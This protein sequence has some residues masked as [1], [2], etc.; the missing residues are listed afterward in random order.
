MKIYPAVDIKD[1]NCVRLYQGEFST[2]HKVA[3]SPIDSALD[4]KNKGAE[5]IHIVDLDGSLQKQPVN[6]EIIKEIIIKTGIP[7]E[8]GGGVRTEK[9]AEAYINIG[10]DKVILGSAA[11]KNPDTVKYLIKKYPDNISVGID[12][13][14]GMASIEGW[15]DISNIGYM[16]LAEKF[17]EYG[18]KNIIY[19][20]ISKDGTLRGPNTEHLYNLKKLLDKYG[21][22]LTASGGIKDIS[23]IKTLTDMDIYAA[24]CGKSLYSGTLDLKEAINAGKGI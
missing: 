19:T 6:F 1:G 5:Y 2:V 13:K 23:H 3:H 20:D 8:I 14:D 16:D 7:A 21:C 11:L 4:F 15:T 17:A 24:I 10:A 12:A 18:V 22:T 9:D